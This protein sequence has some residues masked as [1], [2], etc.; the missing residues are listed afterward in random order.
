MTSVNVTFKYITSEKVNF[1]I[2]TCTYIFAIKWNGLKYLKCTRGKEL[3]F[4][5]HYLKKSNPLIS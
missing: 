3:S 1:S 4:F 2:E 5:F